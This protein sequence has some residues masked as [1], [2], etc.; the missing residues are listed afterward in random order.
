VDDQQVS[1]AAEDEADG[2]WIARPP[3]GITRLADRLR[4]RQPAWI[5][6]M[7]PDAT[8]FT[9]YFLL[10][11]LVTARYWWDPHRTSPVRPAD[12][13]W[14]VWL[15]AHVA[16][17]VQHLDNPLAGLPDRIPGGQGLFPGTAGLGSTLPLT[18]ITLWRGPES[19][20]T[21][22]IF[23]GFAGTAAAT[24]WVLS[25]H[26]V[27]SR[28]AAF[29]GALAVAFAPG[30]VWHAN[31]QPNLVV[32]FL[33]PLIVVRTVRLAQGRVRRDGILLGLLITWQFL[34]DP[35]VLLLTALSGGVAALW[36]LWLR[37]PRTGDRPGAGRA[38]GTGLGVA[39]LTSAVLLAVPMWYWLSGPA[40]H[41]VTASAGSRG[42][43]LVT[44]AQYW[45]D[46]LA[47]NYPTGHIVGGIEQNS[48]LGYPL[49]LLAAFSAVLLWRTSRVARLVTLTGVVF[50][51]LSL[52]ATVYADGRSTGI[53]GLWWPL[54][55]IPGVAAL[56]PTRLALVVAVCVGV[57][58]ALAIDRMPAAGPVSA[59][60]TLRRVWIVA[61]LV[62][63]VPTLPG[64]L[65]ATQQINTTPRFIT[66]REWLPYVGK[67]QTVVLVPSTGAGLDAA[68]FQAVARQ[69]FAIPRDYLTGPDF[70][71][72][73]SAMSERSP[74]ARL[75]RSVA[76]SGAVP[77]ITP[78]M[79][80]AAVADLRA[81]H[82]AVLVLVG[83][84]IREKPVRQV[85]IELT[86]IVPGW[87][88][89]VY[90]WDVRT[91]VSQDS[92]A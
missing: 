17:A 78:E 16:H 24:Y 51:A 70:S 83:G 57:L 5:R 19:A 48:W 77:Q 50:A 13:V 6:R 38:V 91:L 63:L 71:A 58:L 41:A 68:L 92:T 65:Q 7:L 12:H 86:G 25:R 88:D 62:A 3:R 60:L 35:E 55:R 9:L 61:V 43:D 10:T 67:G 56:P 23:L 73:G 4:E 87:T 28:F 66:A 15:L 53:P 31:G 44:F 14:S 84:T 69:E 29:V 11:A 8:A 45:R 76:D 18:P 39:L 40:G 37:G 79:R 34:I 22:W 33:V 81:W 80:R 20:Y 49:L 85:V 2:D 32:N 46:S 72:G 52:G 21:W 30:L 74:T 36:Y 64:P 82:A 42:E 26:L 1:R 54:G 59:G 90:V 75:L 27:T 89:G 47:G